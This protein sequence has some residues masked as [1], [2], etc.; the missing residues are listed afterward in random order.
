[1]WPTGARAFALVIALVLSASLFVPMPRARGAE[2]ERPHVVAKNAIVVDAATGNVLY[3]KSERERVAPASLT[4]LFTAAVA[5][6]SVPLDQ[7]MT[8]DASALVGE[9][10]MGLRADEELPFEA[11]LYGMLLAS[12]NDAALATAANVGR[13]AGDT[14]RQASA[15]F[16]D[17]ANARLAELGI[18]ETHL[19]NPHGLDQDGHYSTARDIAAITI[20]AL[21]SEPAIVAALGTTTYH[22]Y[23]HTLQHTNELLGRYP[24]LL[25]GKTGFTSAAGFCLMEIAER[26]GRTVVAVLLGSTAEQWYRDAAIL[27]DYGFAALSTP[28]IPRQGTLD[29]AAESTSVPVA[30]SSASEAKVSSTTGPV[31]VM[32]QQPT[33][34]SHSPWRWL[35]TA[36]IGTLV[37]IFVT[38][39]LQAA[40]RA[41]RAL[42]LR[43]REPQPTR[44]QPARGAL[45]HSATQPLPALTPATNIVQTAPTVSASGLAH[46]GVTLAAQ[47]HFEAAARAFYHAARLDDRLDLTSTPG[48]WSLCPRGHSAAARALVKAGRL[49]DARSLAVVLGLGG[50]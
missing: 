22:S 35:S 17:R 1:V 43:V 37:I 27:L 11:L 36:L 4:K 40:W 44:A 10:S 32:A 49:T 24:G 2:L 12:G 20:H 50:T 3:A 46:R 19:A 6:E 34:P 5:V 18:T 21:R 9:A 30:D 47:Q 42:R 16:I 28:G 26:D 29:I 38:R 39:Q 15:R 13:L 31:V 45:W 7:F 33:F 14:P 8:V 41:L 25:G 48:F 23:G